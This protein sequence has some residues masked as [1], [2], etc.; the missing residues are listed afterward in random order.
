MTDIMN[1]LLGKWKLLITNEIYICHKVFINLK[2]IFTYV[3]M[4]VHKKWHT[5][6]YETYTNMCNKSE[7]ISEWI[8]AKGSVRMGLTNWNEMIYWLW[9][10]IFWRTVIARRLNL[11]II[12]WWRQ[13]VVD[14][15]LCV[16]SGIVTINWLEKQNKKRKRCCLFMVKDC[17]K[18]THKEKKRAAYK[19][20]VMRFWKQKYSSKMEK[21]AE[22]MRLKH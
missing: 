10:I 20:A 18:A 15:F 6:M 19:I 5:Y 3:K 22:K 12:W 14:W 11:I 9:T 4:L 8:I 13:G 17:I 1:L 21:I 7:N 2:N 16:C